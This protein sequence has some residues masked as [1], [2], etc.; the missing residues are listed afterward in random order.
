MA[1][2]L[3]SIRDS[4]MKCAPLYSLLDTITARICD[5]Q[6][7]NSQFCADIRGPRM[8]EAITSIQDFCGKDPRN[9]P[10]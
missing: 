6:M 4:F 10:S 1:A 9:P 2:S 5:S 3:R 7:G 8:R